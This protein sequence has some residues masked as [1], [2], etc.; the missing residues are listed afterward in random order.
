MNDK[1][2]II[3]RFV[4][5][6]LTILLLSI[7]QYATKSQTRS[8]LPRE[9]VGLTLGMSRADAQKR[10]EQIGEFERDDRKQQ[11]V[12]RLKD[13]P[14]YSHIVLG[15]DASEQVRYLTAFVDRS[16]ARILFSDIGDITKA[17]QEI[18]EPHYKYTWEVPVADGK[19]SYLVVAYGNEPDLLS[20]CS[21]SKVIVNAETEKEN[22]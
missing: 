12:W 8:S 13:D 3:Y 1:K 18:V 5:S 17:K 2:A 4:L 22:E 20:S 7:S 21:L 6:G 9:I 14:R 19:A 11:Q 16:K 10:L 15:F